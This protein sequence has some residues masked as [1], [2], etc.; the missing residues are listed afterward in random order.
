M[1]FRRLL[2]TCVATSPT[3]TFAPR[4]VVAS[5]RGVAV[6]ALPA[7]K[8]EYQL[9]TNNTALCICGPRPFA[10]QPRA[11]VASEKGVVVGRLSFRED[12][13]L[14]DC[15]RMGV[16]GK[17]IPPNIDKV[18]P[19]AAACTSPTRM[20]ACG[21]CY[22]HT[23]AAAANPTGPG[24]PAFVTLQRSTAT[25]RLFHVALGAALRSTNTGAG[26]EEGFF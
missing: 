25:I 5:E 7:H 2:C 9:I 11:V 18:R 10:P 3:N 13:D 22:Y 15:Q 24:G 20:A 6:T 16:G 8:H 14:I 23:C 17:A 4:A 19:P 26:A 12:G 1:P 21:T